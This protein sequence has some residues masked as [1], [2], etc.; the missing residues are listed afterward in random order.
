MDNWVK[1][2]TDQMGYRAEIVRSYL[3]DQGIKAIIL[4]KKDSAFKLGKLE[5]YVSPGDSL[6]AANMINQDIKFD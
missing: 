3:S 1:V 2:Y 6:K 4:D 5:V